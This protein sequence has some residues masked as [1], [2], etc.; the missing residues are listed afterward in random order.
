MKGMSAQDIS[1]TVQY[2]GARH[3]CEGA[4]HGDEGCE[5]MRH[6]HKWRETWAQ[7]IATWVQD[8]GTRHG[9]KGYE[10]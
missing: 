1:M 10:T 7:D 6:E 2:M 8:K 4:R 5:G 3:W 9:C